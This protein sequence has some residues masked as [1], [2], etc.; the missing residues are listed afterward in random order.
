MNNFSEKPSQD[1]VEDIH[2]LTSTELVRQYLPLVKSIAYRVGGRFP[3]NVELDDLINVGLIGL[4]DAAEKYRPD[5]G[6]SFKAYAELRIRGSILD[7]LRHMD[8]V[9][10]SVRKKMQSLE[11][12]KRTLEKSL[13]Q[14]PTEIQLAEAMGMRLERYQRVAELAQGRSLLS[15]EDVGKNEED[16][17]RDL[18]QAVG[19]AEELP[20]YRMRFQE[21]REQLTEALK[22]LPERDMVMITLYYF[23]E[24][25]L[26]EISRVLGV[27]ESRVSQIH[28]DALKRL[29]KKLVRMAF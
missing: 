12:T 10:R 14:S 25:P 8:W 1:M 19:N 28:G 17:S 3:N 20:D 29:K 24:L 27:T 16:E 9:P 23:E 5:Q 4:V 18:L 11:R 7:E 6:K 15:L 22:E 2:A 13:G 26:K 21:M